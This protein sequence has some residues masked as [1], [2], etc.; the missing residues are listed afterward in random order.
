MKKHFDGWGYME[1]DYFSNNEL[2]G[3]I[4]YWDK[5]HD[6]FV[7]HAKSKPNCNYKDVTG[8]AL[9]KDNIDRAFLAAFG[10]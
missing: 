9:D 10:A 3:L 5:P 4:I 1:V 8:W 6:S 7:A 2:N